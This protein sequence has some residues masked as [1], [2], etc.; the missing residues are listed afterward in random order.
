M[1]KIPMLTNSK[2][3]NLLIFLA[4]FT[5]AIPLAGYTINGSYMRYS[6]DD[7]CDTA[8]LVKFGFLGAFRH[9]YLNEG[10]RF[11]AVLMGEIVGL[12]DPKANGVLPGLAIFL[13]VGGLAF[14]IRMGT[15]FT[16]FAH[17]WL[18]I[19]LGAEFLVF[20]TLYEAPILSQSFYW[21]TGLLAY[22]TPLIFTTYLTGFVF[23]QIKRDRLSPYT[24]LLIA[25]LAFLVGGFSESTVALSA[26][27]W[28][29]VFIT[30]FIM[31]NMKIAWASRAIWLSGSALIGT[32]IAALVI[33]VAPG[34]TVRQLHDNMPRTYNILSLASISMKFTWDFLR[35][36]LLGLP[37]P[38]A[39]TF[40][41]PM[42]LVV[43][44]A[45]RQ[46]IT[47]CKLTRQKIA[48]FLLIPV[49]GYLLMMCSIAPHVFAYTRYPELRVLLLACFVLVI[50][51]AGMGCLVAGVVVAF[52]QRLS[53]KLSHVAIGVI[54][55]LLCGS[56]LY[57]I[58]AA[59][60]IFDETP[61]YQKW[62]TFWDARDREI[63]LAR[64]K[65]NL[66]LEVVAIDHIITWVGELSPDPSYWYNVCASEYYRVNSI[67]ANQPGWNK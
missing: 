2:T 44:L 42:L 47:A 43:I 49:A 29:L 35:G 34:N 16:P 19:L 61:L 20:I 11:S 14:T 51:L 3:R 18:E 24:L 63:R 33:F 23:L 28:A 27:F 9:Y 32:L 46:K 65:G 50:T 66:D 40:T 41:Y 36:S 13:W 60:R 5:F 62:A 12:L 37:I 39:L 59:R 21:R 6:G 53:L 15:K 45:S 31:R 25:F 55:I 22:L 54:I 17:S 10:G 56:S 8:R 1:A 57:P 30:C 58:Y 4:C 64:E 48:M 26:G 67:S 52:L 7:Y 38:F